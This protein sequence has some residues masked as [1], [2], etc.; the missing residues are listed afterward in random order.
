MEFSDGKKVGGEEFLYSIARMEQEDE[1]TSVYSSMSFV[2]VLGAD[3]CIHFVIP[4][5]RDTR[6]SS[7]ECECESPLSPNMEL[8]GSFRMSS[9]NSVCG[10]KP[11]I[12]GQKHEDS[13]SHIVDNDVFSLETYVF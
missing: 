8:A 3:V 6:Y 10:I 12:L 5:D 13:P 7:P 4:R 2:S 9:S 1:V 11:S